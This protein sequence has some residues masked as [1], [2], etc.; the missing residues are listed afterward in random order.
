MKAKTDVVV[1]IVAALVP[2]RSNLTYRIQYGCTLIT[3]QY[4]KK[5]EDQPSKV[6]NPARGQLKRE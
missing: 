1:V 2:P 4:S 6:A 3:Y 5:R